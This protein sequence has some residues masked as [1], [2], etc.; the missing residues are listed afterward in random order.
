MTLATG[1]AAEVNLSEH[2]NLGF[3]A[4]HKARGQPAVSRLCRKARSPYDLRYRL[5][6]WHILS[7]DHSGHEVSVTTIE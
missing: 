3:V 2:M 7:H 4:T 5:K 1:G 6:L